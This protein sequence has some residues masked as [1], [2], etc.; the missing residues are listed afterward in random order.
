MYVWPKPRD[1][2]KLRA[3]AHKLTLRM[4]PK[5]R[6]FHHKIGAIWITNDPSFRPPGWDPQADLRKARIQRR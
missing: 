1:L 5:I 2:F 3:G 6:E 4:S